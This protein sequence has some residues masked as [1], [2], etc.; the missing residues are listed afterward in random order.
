[1]AT[2]ALINLDHADIKTFIVK[3]GTTTLYGKAVKHDASDDS[4]DNAGANEDLAIGIALD[5]VVGDGVK[6]VQVALLSGAG[7]LPCL[8]GTGGAT[9]GKFAVLAADGATDAAA[10]G[11]TNA[12]PCI[13]KFLQSG[14]A[15]DIVGLMPAITRITTT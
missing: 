2:R 10:S 12:R 7:V 15:G 9:R 8:V 13:G 3:S 6:K 14:V 1:M 4:V 11:V 5:S